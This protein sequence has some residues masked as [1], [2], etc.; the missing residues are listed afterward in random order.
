MHIGFQRSGKKLEAGTGGRGEFEV[1]GS[2]SGYTAISLEAWTFSLMWPDQIVRETDLWLDPAGSGKPRLRSLRDPGQRF[3]IGKM[4]AAMLLLPDPVRDPR[5][6]GSTLPI[7]GPNGFAVTRL[8]FGP[9]T[10]FAEA[11][12]LVTIDPTFVNVTNRV[13]T[14]SLG[15]EK[16]WARISSVY[17][18]A[19]QFPP[20]VQTEL[21]RH[22]QFM[23]SGAAVDKQLVSIVRLLGKRLHEATSSF[24]QGCDP[25]PELERLAGIVPPAGPS[26]PPPDELGEDEPE[27]SARSAYQYRLAKVRGPGQAAFSLGV[28][29]AYGQRCVFCGGRY[30]GV[31][32]IM[33]GLEGAHILAWSRYDLDEVQNGLSLCK[34]H[35]WAF[36]AALLVPVVE[37]G[38]YSIRFTTLTEHFDSTTMA[39][40]G[41]DGS[42]IP[43]EWLPA[44]PKLRPNPHYLTRLHEDLAVSFLP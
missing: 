16:R 20:P 8:G 28:R 42:I 6:G 17:S 34:T 25:L 39:L 43:E 21:E 27:V 44:D 13:D 18:A 2:H 24:T 29:A 5:D 30:G 15:I 35:H 38:V 1:V 22:R 23:A 14:E 7:V 40:L 37:K 36:D 10:E 41:S 31:Q 3:Q 4:V 9:Q 26:L 12:D 32:G 11:A 19:D 33:S